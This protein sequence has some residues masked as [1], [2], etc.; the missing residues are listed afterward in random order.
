MATVKKRVATFALAA[1]LALLAISFGL[2]YPSEALAWDN[3]PKGLVNDPYPGACRRYVDTNGDDICDLSQSEPVESTTTTTTAPKSET[4]TTTLA[5]TTTTSGEPPTGDCP[6]G[7]C[8][9]CG[10]CLSISSVVAAADTD[11]LAASSDSNIDGTAVAAGTVG[12]AAAGDSATT[13]TTTPPSGGSTDS[14]AAGTSASGDAGATVSATGTGDSG[15]ASFFTGYNV[16]PIAVAFF[17]IYGVSFVLHKTKKIKVTT[18]RKI[19][20][21]LLLATFLITGIFGLILTIQLDYELPFTIPFDLLF[22]HVEAGV[23]MTLIS[24][25]HVSWH[26]NYYRNLLRRSRKTA[27]AAR[28]AEQARPADQGQLVWEAREQR[29]VER[30]ARRYKPPRLE[31]PPHLSQNPRPA[32]NPRPYLPPTGRLEPEPD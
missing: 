27:R 6:L 15:G 22:W 20:N 7:P 11:T 4:T 21:V 31:Q 32:Q 12:L 18:H 14:S 5:V 2:A 24:I 1:T 8:A 30:E 3:C 16:S 19:W 13:S 23:A 25:F 26:F 9:G 17:L 10:A 28:A 29:R